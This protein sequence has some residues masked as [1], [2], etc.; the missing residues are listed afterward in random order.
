MWREGKVDLGH[1]E[2]DVNVGRQWRVGPALFLP[3]A[4]VFLGKQ[5]KD[6]LIDR[7]DVGGVARETFTARMRHRDVDDRARRADSIQFLHDRQEHVDAG[8]QMFK[9][10]VHQ[11][12][13]DRVR[14]EWPGGNFKIADDF[15]RER[16]EFIDVDVAFFQIAGEDCFQSTRSQA[17]SRRLFASRRVVIIS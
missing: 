12:F 10:V 5:R 9:D 3:F 6:M 11:D 13:I 2:I 8:T 1:V 17:A 15:R 16:V 14:L 7:P 4:V